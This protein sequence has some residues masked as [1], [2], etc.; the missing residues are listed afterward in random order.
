MTS[1]LFMN[2]RGEGATGSLDTREEGQNMKKPQFFVSF[3]VTIFTIFISVSGTPGFT[4]QLQLGA[5]GDTKN[6][7]IL[8]LFCDWKTIWSLKYRPIDKKERQEI[9]K[10][11]AVSKCPKKEVFHNNLRVAVFKISKTR[12]T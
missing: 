9:D 7:Y 6:D 4:E 5:L 1:V 3:G 8:Y 12:T 10:I 2:I 11:V